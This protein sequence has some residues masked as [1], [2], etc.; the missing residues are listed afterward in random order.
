MREGAAGS[1][2]AEEKRG[3]AHAGGEPREG[4]GVLS[5]R[6]AGGKW[7]QLLWKLNMTLCGKH[8]TRL[9]DS[10]HSINYW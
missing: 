8:L 5:G 4:A 2:E 3:W 9:S 10:R 1:W 6:Q 7:R